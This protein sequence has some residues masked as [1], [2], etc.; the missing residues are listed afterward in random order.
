MIVSRLL[1][2]ALICS[3][4]MAHAADILSGPVFTPQRNPF[5]PALPGIGSNGNSSAEPVSPASSEDQLELR[6]IIYDGENSLANINGSIVRAG[7]VAQGYRVESVDSH[8]VL[9]SSDGKRITLMLYR[10]LPQ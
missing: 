3:G 1:A 5:Q 10:T 9:L 8:K 7:D 6:A 4:C 2:T